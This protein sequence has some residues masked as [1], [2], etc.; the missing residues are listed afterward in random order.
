MYGKY[1]GD[2]VDNSLKVLNKNYNIFHDN[3][4]FNEEVITRL[5]GYFIENM[6]SFNKVFEAKWVYP[7]EIKTATKEVVW[8]WDSEDERIATSLEI[9]RYGFYFPIVT[10][11]Q[12]RIHGQ[13]CNK[14][15][16]KN[17]KGRPYYYT[18]DGN[19]RVDSIH[20]LVEKGIWPQDKKVLIYI[21]PDYCTFVRQKIKL[22]RD[23]YTTDKYKM[24]K[25]EQVLIMNYDTKILYLDKLENEIY[26][27]NGIS[28]IDIHHYLHFYNAATAISHILT[29]VLYKYFEKHNEPVPEIQTLM[30]V[31]N[32]Y[33]SW[34]NVIGGA[35]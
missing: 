11:K 25:L 7:N 20:Y 1:S 30:K 16:L 2:R 29:P 5:Y 22:E 17:L 32:D 26:V 34:N 31:F 12:G 9:Y 18:V 24:N 8:S 6:K 19:H 33:D 15:E 21:V 4:E 14:E 3:G 23:I 28:K 35:V 27:E 13:K 10:L